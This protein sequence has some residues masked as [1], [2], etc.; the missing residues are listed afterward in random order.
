MRLLLKNRGGTFLQIQADMF[1][2]FN[3]SFFK[4]KFEIQIDWR[5]GTQVIP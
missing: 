5:K 2:Q 1:L 3:I 4:F